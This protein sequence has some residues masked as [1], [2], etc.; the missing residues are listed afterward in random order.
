MQNLID[1]IATTDPQILF[2]YTFWIVL[3]ICCLPMAIKEYREWAKLQD[4]SDRL[5]G[6]RK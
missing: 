2:F 5:L 6:K 3:V 4:E 1:F